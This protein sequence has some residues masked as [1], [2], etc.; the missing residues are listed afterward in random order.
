L[1]QKTIIA[2]TRVIGTATS[3]FGNNSRNSD[4]LL[5]WLRLVA[6]PRHQG[7]WDVFLGRG[8]GMWFISHFFQQQAFSWGKCGETHKGIR[9]S[10]TFNRSVIERC[11]RR[12]SDVSDP[13]G[14]VVLPICLLIVQLFVL[15][16]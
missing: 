2:A 7:M 15:P 12:R 11:G 1:L 16:P 8:G 4:D 9:W 5:S 6:W 14:R 13:L 10:Q 3:F